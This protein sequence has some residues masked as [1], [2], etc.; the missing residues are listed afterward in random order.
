[1][2][3]N[4]PCND[5]MIPPNEEQNNCSGSGSWYTCCDYDTVDVVSH[6]NCFFMNN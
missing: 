2:K 4:K 3:I 6:K 5:S 1:M